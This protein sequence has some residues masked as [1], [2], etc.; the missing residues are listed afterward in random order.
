MAN[1]WIK[2]LSEEEIRNKFTVINAE[3]A[4]ERLNLTQEAIN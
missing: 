1:D 3:G 2:S 4:I